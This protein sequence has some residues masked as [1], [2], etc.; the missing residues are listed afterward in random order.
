MMRFNRAISAVKVIS[1]DLDDTL[2]DNRPIIKNAIKTQQDYLAAIP[3]WAAQSGDFWRTCRNGYALENP[4]II[5]DVTL[6]RQKALLWGLETLKVEN[7]AFHATQA[8]NAFAKAR[9]NIEVATEV[10]DLLAALRKKYKVIAITNG[11]VDVSQF[12]LKDSFDLVLQAGPH[13]KAKPA[14]DMFNLACQQLGVSQNEI[15]HVGDSLDSDVQ[16]ANNAGCYSVWLEN[17][18]VP[19]CYKGLADM[20]ISDIFALK[21]LLV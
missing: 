13:G 3:E 2:Y 9:S 10:I 19:Y 7:A 4:E 6:W 14:N 21:S 20:E 1:F 18:F 12:N 15:L 16:G 11:N 17:A 8:Y 5:N